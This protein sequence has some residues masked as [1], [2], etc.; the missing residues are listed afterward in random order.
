MNQTTKTPYEWYSVLNWTASL[1]LWGLVA[2]SAISKSPGG[3]IVFGLTWAIIGL[4]TVG[5]FKYFKRSKIESREQ[6]QI[7]SEKADKAVFYACIFLGVLFIGQAIFLKSI[8]TLG[9][10]AIYIAFGFWVKSR[11]TIARWLLAVYAFVSAIFV[12]TQGLSAGGMVPF[13]FF[14]IG[15]SIIANRKYELS[16]QNSD[17]L[18]QRSQEDRQVQSE[19]ISK[20]DISEPLIVQKSMPSSVYGNK[21]FISTPFPTLAENSIASKNQVGMTTNDD[22]AYEKV[23]DELQNNTL[24][25]VQ[26]MRAFSEM[27]GDENKAKALYIQR[28]VSQ[29]ISAED[30][31]IKKIISQRERIAELER[32]KQEKAKQDSEVKERIQRSQEINNNESH[33]RI[34]KEN[35]KASNRTQ[36]I[37]EKHEVAELWHQELEKKAPSPT[38]RV[39]NPILIG[40]ITVAIILAVSIVISSNNGEPSTPPPQP[41]APASAPAVFDLSKVAAHAQSGDLNAQLVLMEKYY[42]GVDVVRDYE[43]SAYWAE[44]AMSQGSPLAQALLGHF[45][46]TGKGVR[47]D[48]QKGI[49][50]L[51]KSAA[52]GNSVGISNLGWHY[53]IGDG[54]PKDSNKA[55]ELAKKAA[56]LGN[57]TGKTNLGLLYE[58]GEG[59]PKD[60]SKALELLKPRAAS[61]YSV[62]SQLA[63][64]R[65]YSDKTGE[66][67]DPILALAWLYVAANNYYAPDESEEYKEEITLRRIELEVSLTSGQLAEARSI[68]SAWKKGTILQR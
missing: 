17:S 12:T 68:A 46:M 38:K 41:L 22:W 48:K 64:G 58:K 40:G 55:F 43:K 59:T 13:I 2:N 60:L 9:D 18:M 16:K 52:R 5:L 44:K 19:N 25:K 7:D 27:G 8:G 39:T 49:E 67:Y 11:S 56:E 10:A 35:I 61:G 31:R 33:D 21:L 23:A 1:F 65:I 32:L 51:Q 66:F 4:V 34:Q 37:K 57:S 6:L 26:W 36:P 50:L 28:R 15:W 47:Q 24:D 53:Q 29:I 20:E 14:A 45:Y 54:V 30:E 63:L 42:S 3:R 62:E